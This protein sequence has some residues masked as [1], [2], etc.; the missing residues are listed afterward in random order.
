MTNI[1]KK[2]SRVYNLEALFACLFSGGY[3]EKGNL[4]NIIVVF[5]GSLFA[6]FR[7]IT[8]A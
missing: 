5:F 6:L 8:A 2:K 4:D 3:F 7:T 1:Y